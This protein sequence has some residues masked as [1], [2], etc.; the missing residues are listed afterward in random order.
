MAT[1]ALASSATPLVSGSPKKGEDR[2]ADIFVEG[3]AIFERDARHLVEIA[4]ENGGQLLGFESLGRLGE[5]DEVGEE[6][7]ELLAVRRDPD[8]L[9]ALEY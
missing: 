9:S 2:I 8:R 1:Q 4:V 7:R 6:D 5:A 3:G